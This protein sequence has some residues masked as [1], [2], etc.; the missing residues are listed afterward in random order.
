MLEHMKGA[1]FDLDG[2]IVDTAKY[3]YLA[4]KALANRLG[5]E[6]TEAHNERLKGVSRVE[7]LRILLEIGGIEV[8]EQTFNEMAE[9]KNKEYVASIA[10]L[11]PEE[12]LPGA[13][14]YLQQLRSQGVKIALG[15]ASKNAEFI[16]SKLEIADLFDA[17]IDGNKVSKAKPD[18]EVFVSASVALGLDPKDCVVFE[19]AE[20]G[21]QAGKAA[22]SKVVGI[23]SPEILREAD[24]V[25]AG[26]A[27]LAG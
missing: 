7:S 22:G 1:I 4:W 17:V 24:L 16:L 14:A 27:E 12:I 19:D 3:H 20:A 18:P 26:L 13:K 2:V 23:G 15:S 5:F 25:I 21:V 9:S 10:K 8:D 6:F 11:Q